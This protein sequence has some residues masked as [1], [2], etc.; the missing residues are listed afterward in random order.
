[1]ELSP[2]EL[3]LVPYCLFAVHEHLH[4]NQ[5]GGFFMIIKYKFATGEVTEVDVSDEI[6]AVITASRKAEHALEERNR[7]HCYSLNAID[8]E[9]LEYGECDEYPIEDDSAERAER[10]KAAFIYMRTARLC[11]RSPRW[12]TPNSSRWPSPLMLPDRSS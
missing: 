2:S 6:G 12:R 8:Y 11:G 3:R 10:I 7:Y 5:N 4:S 1:M 9:G